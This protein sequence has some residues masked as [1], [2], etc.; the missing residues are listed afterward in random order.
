MA[1]FSSKKILVLGT[2]ALLFLF[3]KY[4]PIMDCKRLV[5]NKAKLFALALMGF[6]QATYPIILVDMVTRHTKAMS[7]LR[8]ESYLK[9]LYKLVSY[10]SL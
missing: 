7:L 8:L 1:L 2:V 6:L 3:G 9:F 10:S 5:N 4:C